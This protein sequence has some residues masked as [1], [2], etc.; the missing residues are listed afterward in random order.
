M[1]VVCPLS[2]L[3]AQLAA[4]GARRVVTLLA[5]GRVVPTPEG[6]APADHLTLGFHDISTPMDGHTPPAAHHVE[7]LLD[8]VG[9]W[10]RAA[11]LLIHCWAGI[12]RSTA[13]AYVTACALN[14]RRDEAEVA[15]RLRRLSPSATPNALI[16]RLADEA[17]GRRGR[18]VR[19]VA[20]IGR[21]RDAFQGEPFVL[22]ID[23]D[24]A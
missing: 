20:A 6:V 3:P 17:L 10:D 11:P 1:I 23:G 14:P 5:E 8:F 13:A 19:A 18:M 24:D 21:G 7:R 4:S 12:S 2:Q 15:L 22:P 9:R 16:V